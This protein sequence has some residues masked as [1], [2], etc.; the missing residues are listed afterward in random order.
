MSG[1]LL[2][3]TWGTVRE[4][5]REIERLEAQVERLM[6][7]IREM[8]TQRGPAFT[9]LPNRKR[10]PGGPFGLSLQ[11]AHILMTLVENAG[12]VVEDEALYASDSILRP[13]R[14]EAVLKVQ[15][16]NIRVRLAGHGFD[17]LIRRERHVGYS[18]PSAHAAL[19]A[20][21]LPERVAAHRS[22]A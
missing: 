22:A 5:A 13:A 16:H 2:P 10:D 18:M 21:H 12:T 14:I 1:D 20:P 11:Q 7:Q 9:R 19:I 8:R 15:V 3:P 17:V 6:R 4:Q